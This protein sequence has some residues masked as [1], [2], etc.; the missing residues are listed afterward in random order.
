MLSPNRKLG[1]GL[2]FECLS[3]SDFPKDSSESASGAD[4]QRHRRSGDAAGRGAN[5]LYRKLAYGKH[6]FGR[7]LLDEKATIEKLTCDDC[8]DFYQ[9]V[10]VPNNTIVAIVGDFDAKAV[11]E[12]VKELTKDWKKTDLPE[13]EVPAVEKPAKVRATHPHH[14][15]VLHFYMGH[16][17]IRRDNADY[18]KLLVM[19]YVLGTG[20]GF[21]D[22]LSA[23]LRDREGLAYTVAP[24]SPM[25]RASSRDCSPAT[26]ALIRA[27]S[28]WSRENF[29]RN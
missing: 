4:R 13:V 10:F 23:Q 6:P 11:V 15:G 28:R 7:S 17:G 22:R 24:P 14:A 16:V 20:P 9:K 27:S 1:L 18:Y 12:E 5:A 8:R 19:D 29:W 26:S 3:Q 2:L 25:R 21:T